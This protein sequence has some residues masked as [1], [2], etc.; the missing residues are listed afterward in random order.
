VASVG[1]ALDRVEAALREGRVDG[2]EQ[3]RLTAALERMR[4][5][6]AGAPA[7]GAL[8]SA[9][10]AA[11]E[12]LDGGDL[13]GAARAVT[14]A[15]GALAPLGK[16]LA[17]WAVAQRTEKAAA[18]LEQV[19]GAAGAPAADPSTGNEALTHAQLQLSGSNGAGASAADDHPTQPPPRETPTAPLQLSGSWNGAVMREL[20]DSASPGLD[21]AAKKVLVDHEQVVEDR[22]RRDDVPAEYRDAVRSYFAALH[23]RGK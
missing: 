10:A 15:R 22:F 4:R 12:K 13:Q 7:G 21:D 19:L 20:F 14:D 9:L 17:R 3:A 23:Q 8:A 6:A 11:A 5:I 18:A 16:P 1:A 2:A